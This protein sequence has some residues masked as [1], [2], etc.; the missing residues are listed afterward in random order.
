VTLSHFTQEQRYQI[1]VILKTE[2]LV[3][4]VIIAAIIT[5]AVV[6]AWRRIETGRGEAEM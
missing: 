6:A 1:Y 3:A 4:K 5:V 2:H